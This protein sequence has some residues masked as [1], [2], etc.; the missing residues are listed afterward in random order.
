MITVMWLLALLSFLWGAVIFVAAKGGIH[1]VYA[2]VTWLISAVLLVGALLLDALRTLQA[3][4]AHGQASQS[5]P[6]G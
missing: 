5:P 3:L 2:T 1:E 4:V 6:G